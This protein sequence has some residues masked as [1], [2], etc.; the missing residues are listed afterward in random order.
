MTAQDWLF[1]GLWLFGYGCLV[2]AIVMS[3]VGGKLWRWY[4]RKHRDK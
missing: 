1:L 2:A 3:D 4:D